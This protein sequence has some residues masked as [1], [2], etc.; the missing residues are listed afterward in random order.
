MNW[1]TL[2]SVA[3]G[4][5]IGVVGGVVSTVLSHRYSHARDRAVAT[6]NAYVKI[7]V[8][9]RGGERKIRAAAR[10]DARPL[11]SQ[12]AITDLLEARAW[13][14]LASE[15]VRKQYYAICE[16]LIDFR[17]TSEVAE[18]WN[19]HDDVMNTLLTL[20]KTMIA[21]LSE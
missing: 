6:R 7:L 10:V 3:I 14:L 4:G 15:E 13:C 19:Q 17:K 2:V 20:E 8:G 21:D 12:E 9:A 5:G 1:N 16:R 18:Y 11:V